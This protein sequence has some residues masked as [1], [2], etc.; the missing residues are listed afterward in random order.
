MGNKKWL[1]VLWDGRAG[2]Q[3]ASQ[4]IR[5]LTLGVGLRPPEK[6]M[7]MRM[8]WLAGLVLGGTCRSQI[9]LLC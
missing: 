6:G 3:G 4:E 8:R 5:S 7:R 9:S 2:V 1:R